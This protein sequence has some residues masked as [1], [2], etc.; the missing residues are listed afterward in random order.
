[1]KRDNSIT[2]FFVIV[3]LIFAYAIYG[4]I[5]N[6]PETGYDDYGCRRNSFNEVICEGDR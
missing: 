2:W 3:G 5:T 1:M 6:P 4:R